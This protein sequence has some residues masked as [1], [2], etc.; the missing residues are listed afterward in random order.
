MLHE[1]ITARATWNS[2]QLANE[3]PAIAAL[4]AEIGGPTSEEALLQDLK[5]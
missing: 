2:D 5:S 4:T 3:L 1:V